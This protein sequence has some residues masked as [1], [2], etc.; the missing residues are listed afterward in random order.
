MLDEKLLLL[1]VARLS[2]E[3]TIHLQT[4]TGVHLRPLL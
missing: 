2:T 3:E 1:N 4:H